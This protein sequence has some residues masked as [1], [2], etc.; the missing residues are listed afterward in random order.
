M[1]KRPGIGSVLSKFP[2]S[3]KSIL[4]IASK[5]FPFPL[6]P[7][8]S[9]AFL[10]VLLPLLPPVPLPRQHFEEG[11][12]LIDMS[13]QTE[14]V[15]AGDGGGTGCSSGSSSSSSSTCC[16]WWW[17]WGGGGGSAGAVVDGE[18]AAVAAA[19]CCLALLPWWG[20]A[21]CPGPVRRMSRGRWRRRRKRL[22]AAAAAAAVS[23]VAV[24]IAASCSV[25]VWVDTAFVSAS[26]TATAAVSLRSGVDAFGV[27]PFALVIRVRRPWPLGVAVL[28]ALLCPCVAAAAGGGGWPS[29]VPNDGCR[30]RL[31][32]RRR[33]CRRREAV[34]AAAAAA[35]GCPP[36]T[37]VSI[38]TCRAAG[39]VP[40]LLVLVVLGLPLV[41]H[42]FVPPSAPRPLVKMKKT[43]KRSL[44]LD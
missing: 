29:W 11:L 26:S 25:A 28:A 1:S 39:F 18:V 34:A 38:G 16:W 36:P 20:T 19:G 3:K 9:G 31:P 8:S 13:G 23:G 10:H 33:R 30:A 17:W 7:L 15:I 2:F 44:S 6:D 37:G 12:E 32:R 27:A 24:A 43:K 4:W 5:P 40:L 14:A 35:G 42:V 22:W 41:L 21:G